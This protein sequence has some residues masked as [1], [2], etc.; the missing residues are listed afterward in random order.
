MKAIYLAN[1]I[2]GLTLLSA[3]SEPQQIDAKPSLVN[4]YTLPEVENKVIRE[5][6]GVARA[7]DL[8]QLSFRVE[9]RIADIPVSKGQAIKKGD[10]LAV[11]EK[12]DFQI[13]L[14]DRRARREVAE[15]QASRIKQLIDKKLIAQVEYDQINAQYLVARAQEK[16]AA[17]NLQY[18]ELKAPFDGLISDV[19]LE[20]FENVQPGKPVLSAQKNQRVEVDIQIPDMLIA[21]SRRASDNRDMRF[22]VTFEAFDDVEFEGQFLE[23]STEKD[24]KTSTYIATISVELDP[25]YKV[26]EGMP[27]RVEVDLSDITYTYQREYLLPISAVVMQDGSA[28][29][30]QQSG[31]WVYNE[32]SQTVNYQLVRLGVIAGDQIEVVEGLTDGQVIV[33]S[34]TSRLVEG[35]KVELVKG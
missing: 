26:L 21:V 11:L 9:G 8:T 3:C 7:Q 31:V 23:V 24:P 25:N 5:F 34:G 32:G 17:L 20:S 12:R 28:L 14:E 29:A 30:K 13:A 2:I 18:T 16:Q 6:N 15:K 19:F 27:A 22:R 33:T 10:V 4:V 35:Q 1:T